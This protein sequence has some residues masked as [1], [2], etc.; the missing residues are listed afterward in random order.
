MH[1]LIRKSPSL[2]FIDNLGVQFLRS[3]LPQI[4]VFSQKFEFQQS[5]HG[6]R[7]GSN[8]FDAL[9]NSYLPLPASAFTRHH[10]HSKV[11]SSLQQPFLL[12]AGFLSV[13]ATPLASAKAFTTSN[14]EQPWPLP[15][16]RL[17]NWGASAS[18][19]SRSAWWPAARSITW[20]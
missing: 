3:C 16:L 7:F 13:M 17:S 2:I 15:R 20:M 5:V 8:V 6:S 1:R 4:Q 10:L 11:A 18:N 19:T 14:T 9:N 12:E